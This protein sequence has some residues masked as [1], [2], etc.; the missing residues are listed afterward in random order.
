L[1]PGY[2]DAHYNLAL[3]YQGEGDSLKA[4]KHWRAYL[5]LD[6]QGYWAAIARRELARVRDEAVIS[7]KRAKGA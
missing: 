7:G 5:K 3:L 4:L 1:D 6:P 2:A